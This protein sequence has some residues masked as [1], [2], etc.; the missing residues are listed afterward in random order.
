M[1]WLGHENHI[2]NKE[3][4]HKFQ[5]TALRPFVKFELILWNG[6]LWQRWPEK[7]M[8]YP[9]DILCKGF[10]TAMITSK[11]RCNVILPAV[12]NGFFWNAWTIECG[13]VLSVK[14]CVNLTQ[15]YCVIIES[16]PERCRQSWKIVLTHWPLCNAKC[17]CYHKSVIA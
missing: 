11:R 17:V 1:T 6:R 13:L 2:Q 8:V 15:T 5:L 14:E 9:V 10:I 7:H 16:E 12:S 4:L 3:N